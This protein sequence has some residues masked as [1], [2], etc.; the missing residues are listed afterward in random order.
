ML[1]HA[2]AFAIANPTIQAK[3]Y[4]A[5][6]AMLS[7]MPAALRAR[8]LKAYQDAAFADDDRITGLYDMFDPMAF[9][10]AA[11]GITRSPP[12]DRPS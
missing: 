6:V 7:T 10:V 9:G 3:E 2:C 12:R 8:V 1:S 5:Y 4:L 11:C